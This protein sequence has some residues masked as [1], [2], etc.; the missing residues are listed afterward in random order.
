MGYHQV[1]CA[2]RRGHRRHVPYQHTRSLA[3]LR[4][5]SP[6]FPVFDHPLEP[7]G[8]AVSNI[9]RSLLGCTAQASR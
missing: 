9:T 8:V 7:W 6:L 5:P 3:P 4:A 2:P 1:V